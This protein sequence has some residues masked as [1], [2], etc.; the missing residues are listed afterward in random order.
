MKEQSN[1]SNGSNMG[2]ISYRIRNN[3]DEGEFYSKCEKI[4]KEIFELGLTPVEKDD[5]LIKSKKQGDILPTNVKWNDTKLNNF[6]SNNPNFELKSMVPK[7]IKI[8]E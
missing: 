4:K 2:K 6:I 3:L 1:L 5:P 7:K 8:E